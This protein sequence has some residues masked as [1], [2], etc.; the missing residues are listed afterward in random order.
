MI[1]IPRFGTKDFLPFPSL[2]WSVFLRKS[3]RDD[4]PLNTSTDNYSRYFM[5]RT[6]KIWKVGVFHRYYKS[7]NSNVIINFIK[8]QLNINGI[9]STFDFI[10]KLP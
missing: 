3:V 1:K 7:E 10:K 9:S 5:G 6:K 2:G 8:K 4:E